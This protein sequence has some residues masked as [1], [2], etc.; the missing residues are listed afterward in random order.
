LLL[1]K[2][3]YFVEHETF[4]FGCSW[5]VFVLWFM[6]ESFEVAQPI[7]LMLR[8]ES[9]NKSGLTMMSGSGQMRVWLLQYKM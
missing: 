7:G 9:R 1:L 5:R 2:R 6:K 3:F 8:T 4:L